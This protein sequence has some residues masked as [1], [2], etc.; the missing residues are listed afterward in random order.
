MT[1]IEELAVWNQKRSVALDA[2]ANSTDFKDTAAEYR[3]QAAM[4]RATAKALRGR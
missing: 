2:L 1:T 4:H 3:K